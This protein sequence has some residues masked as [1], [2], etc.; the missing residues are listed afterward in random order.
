MQYLIDDSGQ[1]GIEDVVGTAA[2][3]QFKDISIEIPTFGLTDVPYWFRLA[4]KYEGSQQ[5]IIK[6]LEIANALLE[7]I[8]L[9][10]I[11]LSGQVRQVQGGLARPLTAPDIVSRHFVSRLH[12]KPNETKWIYI[13]VGG[14]SVMNLPTYLWSLDARRYKTETQMVVFGMYY[15]LMTVMFLYNLFLFI[16][17][18]FKSYLFYLFYIAFISMT[19]FA[20]DG[21]MKEYIINDSP[22]LHTRLMWLLICI[23]AVAAIFFIREFLATRL[24]HPKMDKILLLTMGLM[25]FGALLTI[26]SNSLLSNY[27]VNIGVFFVCGSL[28]TSGI[29]SVSSGYHEAKFFLLAWMFILLGGVVL[30]S[31]FIGLLPVKSYTMFATHIGSALEVLLLSFVVADRINAIVSEKLVIEKVAKTELENSHRYLDASHR[32]KD[33]FLA[34]ISEEFIVP[35]TGVIKRLSLLDT[36]QLDQEQNSFVNTITRS[37]RSMMFLVNNLIGF[38]EKTNSVQR[39]VAPFGLRQ[40]L[41]YIRL[42]YWAKCQSK[43]LGFQYNIDE[44]IPERLIGDASR[45]QLVIYNLLDNAIKFTDHGLVTM[46]VGRRLTGGNQ[47]TVDLDFNITDTGIGIPEEQQTSIFEPFFVIDANTCRTHAGLG[48]GLALCK[49][50]AAVMNAEISLSSKEGVGTQSNFSV[51]FELE[52][53]T[54]FDPIAETEIPNRKADAQIKDTEVGVIEESFKGRRILIAEDNLINQTV[55][56]KIVEKLG[57]VAFVANDGNEAVQLLKTETVDLIFMDCQMPNKNGYDAT[58]E[59]R[60]NE[61]DDIRLPIVAVTANAMEGDRKKCLEAGMDDYLKKP[62]K[63]GEIKEALGKFL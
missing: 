9:Y 15:G 32:L 52:S 41:E 27:V 33:D 8:D 38:T 10:E 54:F 17:T 25:I 6:E 45:L 35:I 63:L 46:S 7:S 20:N 30:I 57:C 58:Q 48:I 3:K 43:G 1:L 44:N 62:I 14:N 26:A 39:I 59:I 18:R 40:Q 50:T 53:N 60:K 61:L 37:A 11:D 56:K 29:V 51:S 13:K 16:S 55:L 34:C 12:L 24:R 23:T 49:K 22:W 28:L 21:L 4:L 19:M 5:E 47:H 36:N 2:D 42:R 31:M